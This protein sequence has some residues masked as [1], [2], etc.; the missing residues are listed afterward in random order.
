ML[1]DQ[2]DILKNYFSDVSLRNNN[3]VSDS[4]V[5]SIENFKFYAV[6]RQFRAVRRREEREKRKIKKLSIIKFIHIVIIINEHRITA[7]IN[8]DS[9]V[10]LLSHQLAKQINLKLDMQEK[11]TLSIINDKRVNIYD[12]HFLNMKINDK[13]NHIR[14]FHEFFLVS[15][16]IHE[17]VIL[18]MF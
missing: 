1:F 8:F 15:D 5:N 13:L 6:V 16:I 7:L 4:D 14:Y 3:D 11:I 10:N 12:I 9:E 2:I 18:N 17:E